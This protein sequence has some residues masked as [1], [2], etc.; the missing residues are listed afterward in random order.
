MRAVCDTG[1]LLH[2]IEAEALDTL[3]LIDAVYLPPQVAIEM[4]YLLPGWHIPRWL[5]IDTLNASHAAEAVAWQQ[6]DL[7]HAGEAEAIALARQIGAEW[8]LTDDAAAR[9]FAGELGLE[10]HGSL[11][12]ILWAAAVGYFT[13]ADA[14]EALTRLIKSSLWLSSRVIGEAWAALEE[15]YQTRK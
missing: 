11:G 4:G 14:E 3:R 12:I 1:P 10:A 6:S 13:R 2:L 7:L 15:I 5:M 8:L 9:L